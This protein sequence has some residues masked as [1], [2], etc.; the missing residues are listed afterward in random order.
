ANYKAYI[1]DRHLHCVPVGCPG[2]LCLGGVGLA[3]GYLGD[4][5]KTAA[6]FV[7][8]PFVPGERIYH[9]G[10][11]V[12]WRA[13]GNIEFLGR[14]DRQVKIR[15][16]RIELGEVEATLLSHPDVREATV[17]DWEAAPGDR[18]LAAYVVV[19]DGNPERIAGVR[20]FLA[21][22]LPDYMVPAVIVPMEALPVNSNGKVDRSALP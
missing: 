13:D 10:D 2:E 3:R 17:I 9:T 4:P 20:P 1:L 22:K 6:K 15:G 8:N 5:E 19:P 7:P 14:I 18:R 21:G 11:R 12:R 16:Y